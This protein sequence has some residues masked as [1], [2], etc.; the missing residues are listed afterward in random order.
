MIGELDYLRPV[1]GAGGD[2]L[3][4]DFDVGIIEHGDLTSVRHKLKAIGYS[5]SGHCVQSIFLV[6]LDQMSR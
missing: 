6:Q 2:D 4:G 3:L 5:L 1:H